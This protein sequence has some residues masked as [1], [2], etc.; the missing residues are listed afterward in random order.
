MSEE[1]KIETKTIDPV[2]AELKT[3]IEK[4]VSTR[5]AEEMEKFKK[6]TP[7]Y[8][9][10][11]EDTEGEKVETKEAEPTIAKFA[12]SYGP[13]DRQ[14]ALAKVLPESSSAGNEYYGGII[15]PSIDKRAGG[16][17]FKQAWCRHPFS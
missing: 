8:K 13:Y 5:I 10:I 6:E 9:M 14:E 7:V 3:E 4:M 2:E 16:T 15:N 12:I 1:V 11:K 17:R